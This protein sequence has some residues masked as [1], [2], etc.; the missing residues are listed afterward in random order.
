MKRF[1]QLF[2]LTQIVLLASVAITSLAPVQAEVPNEDPEQECCQHEQQEMNQELKVHLDFYYELLAEKYAPD[3]I[4][5]WK[6]IRSERDLLQKKLKEAKQKGELENGEAIDKTWV[7]EHKKLTDAF[8]AAI[9]KRDEE[10]LRTIMPKLFDHYKK[11]NDVYKE[12]LDL[13]KQT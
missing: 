8:N 1:H 13:T 11:L 5:K 7:D 12:R 6:E 3:E 4:E 2:L 10:Q 9:E